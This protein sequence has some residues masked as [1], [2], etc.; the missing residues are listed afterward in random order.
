MTTTNEP[1]HVT[2]GSSTD[3]ARVIEDVRR[4]GAARAIERDGEVL[5]VIVS[6]EVFRLIEGVPK[7]KW[8]KDKLLAFAGVWSDLDADEFINSVYEA[9]HEAPISAPL[10]P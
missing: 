4:D 10:E 9:R 1:E 8:Q 5:A 3:L 2:L 7:S 6:P